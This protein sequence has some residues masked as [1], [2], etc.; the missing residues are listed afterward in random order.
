MLPLRSVLNR[1]YALLLHERDE[2]QRAEVIDELWAPEADEEAQSLA[3]VAAFADQVDEY[4]GEV[5]ADGAAG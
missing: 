4:I 3:R 2:K 1:A 5:S